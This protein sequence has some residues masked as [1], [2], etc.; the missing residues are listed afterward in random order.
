VHHERMRVGEGTFTLIINLG[1]E[2]KLVASQPSR[3]GYFV[4]ANN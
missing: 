4:T 2:W 3:H 1:A